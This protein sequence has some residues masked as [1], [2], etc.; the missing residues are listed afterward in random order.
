MPDW[1]PF[2]SDDGSLFFVEYDSHPQ[3]LVPAESHAAAASSFTKH[4]GKNGDN[5]RFNRSSTRRSKKTAS[6]LS[7]LINRGTSKQSAST[8]KSFTTPASAASTDSTKVKF[9]E[10]SEGELKHISVFIDPAMRHKFGRRASVAEAILGV[11]VCPFPDSDRVMIAG[12]MPNS[13]LGHDRFV[14]VGDWLKAV[15]DDEVTISSLDGRLLGFGVPTEIRLTLQRMSGEEQVLGAE[16]LSYNQMSN[17]AEFVSN[18]K[19]IFGIETLVDANA[20]GTHGNGV[21]LSVMYLSMADLGE[22]NAEGQDVLFCY[23]E[24]EVN[25]LYGTRGSFLT[26]NSLLRDM[27]GSAPL[28][29][30]IEH[31]GVEYAVVYKQYEE[32]NQIHY[33]YKYV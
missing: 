27:F 28:A 33:L 31:A 4:T 16:G 10:I 30:T 29:T 6:R 9:S 17:W 21:V 5:P 24:K 3:L 7:R 12:Y 25:C 2:V 19:Q 18:A 23:P 11:S 26:L 8:Q 15:N 14:K 32:G 13:A 1:E 22:S 20:S